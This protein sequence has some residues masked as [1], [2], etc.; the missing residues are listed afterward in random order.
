MLR[1]AMFQTKNRGS[2]KYEYNEKLK[3]VRSQLFPENKL[4]IVDKR[5]IAPCF[6]REIIDKF[7]NACG[8]D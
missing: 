4:T 5:F 8:Q 1:R 2:F 6:L 7:I 3:N